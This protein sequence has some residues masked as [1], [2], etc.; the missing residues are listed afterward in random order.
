VARNITFI[1]YQDPLRI[2]SE[3]GARARRPANAIRNRQK[4]VYG[5]GS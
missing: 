5:G 4:C 2:F 3:V 1:A